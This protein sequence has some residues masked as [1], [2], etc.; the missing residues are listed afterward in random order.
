MAWFT[1]LQEHGHEQ[2]VLLANRDVGLQAIVAIHD[3]TLGP[4]LGGVRLFDYATEQAALRDALRLARHMT[5]KSAMAGLDLGGGQA[6]ILADPSQKTEALFRAFGRHL[7]TLGGRFIA[8]ED[9]N[10]T[11]R[12]MEAIKR[13]T[14]FVV[15]VGHSLGGSGDPAPVTAWG[16]F[17]AIRAALEVRHGSANLEGRTVA[18]QGV[19]AVGTRLA[20]HLHQAGAQLVYSDFNEDR[21]RYVLDTFGGAVLEGDA[22]YAAEADVLAPCAIGGVLGPYTIPSIRAPIVAAG[23]NRVLE[24]DRRDASSLRERGITYVPDYVANSGGLISVSS[25]HFGWSRDKV[26]AD[27]AGTFDRVKKVLNRAASERISTDQAATLIAEERI[28]RLARLRR[29]HIPR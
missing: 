29:I 16:L 4:A 14:D 7:E 9:M 2:V 15:G 12:D 3:T 27:A 26:M 21:L 23:A 25:E 17:H 5:Y 22:I 13:E 8:A 19:G 1:E 10:T 24:D 11:V 28:E 18:I 20:G 6:V